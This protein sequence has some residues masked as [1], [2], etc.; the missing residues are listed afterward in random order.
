METIAEIQETSIIIKPQIN[1]EYKDIL[2]NGA[3]C[4]IEKLER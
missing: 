2:T 1:S 3:L 4:F